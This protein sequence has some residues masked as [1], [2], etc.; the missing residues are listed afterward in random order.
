MW[1]KPEPWAPVFG[2]RF[3]P[4]PLDAVK[5]LNPLEAPTEQTAQRH[6]AIHRKRLETHDVVAAAASKETFLEALWK[7]L[8]PRSL[9]SFL[10]TTWIS[11]KPA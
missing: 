9:S 5:P 11:V 7:E 1:F 2:R 3:D 6:L 8:R 4:P 10:R